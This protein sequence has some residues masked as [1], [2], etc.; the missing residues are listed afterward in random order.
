VTR[1]QEISSVLMASAWSTHEIRLFGPP[2][3]GVAILGLLSLPVLAAGVC[4]VIHLEMIETDTKVRQS[5]SGTHRRG[6]CS[7]KRWKKYLKW[8]WS[9]D[10]AFFCVAHVGP[11][12]NQNENLKFKF[13]PENRHKMKKKLC[14]MCGIHRSQATSVEG[15]VARHEEV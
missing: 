4:T 1:S 12:L 6:Q 13:F 2:P 10:V 5:A 9:E 11:F 3:F 15:L 8:K 14:G 7:T